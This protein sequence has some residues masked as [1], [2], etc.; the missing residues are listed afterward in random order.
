MTTKAKTALKLVQPDL[1]QL[2]TVL[3]EAASQTAPMVQRLATH[4]DRIRV[5]VAE[6]KG[7]RDDLIARRDLLLRQVAAAEAGFA[8]HLED[9]EATLKLYEG[10]LNSQQPLSD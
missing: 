6:L 5:E 8:M 7:E 10:G 1:D 4:Q 9:I 3:K 2:E